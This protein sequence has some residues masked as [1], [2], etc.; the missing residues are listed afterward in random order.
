MKKILI[1]FVT[2]AMLSLVVG[3]SL[4]AYASRDKELDKAS[5]TKFS[6]HGITDYEVSPIV[7]K[8]VNSD[9]NN[10]ECSPVCIDIDRDT[11]EVDEDGNPIYAGVV[12]KC[13]NPSPDYKSCKTYDDVLEECTEYET[14]YYTDQELS[15]KRDAW[16]DSVIA[17]AEG[18]LNK[19][20]TG[21]VEE[22][23]KEGADVTIKEKKGVMLP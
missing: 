9:G 7:C 13:Y 23:I 3:L 20:D 6:Q 15:D 18:Y 4:S 21:F 22:E 12:H 10:D 5:V 16:E 11:G 19:L 1:V 2:I 8:D 17:T 14:L